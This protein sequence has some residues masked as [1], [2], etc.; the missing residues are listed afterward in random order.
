MTTAH[1]LLNL[2]RQHFDPRAEP[3]A[4]SAGREQTAVL[5]AATRHGEVIVKAH[6]DRERHNSERNAYRRWAPALGERAPRLL[7]EIDDPPAVVITALPG[8]PVAGLPLPPD[9]ERDVFAQAG[10]ILAAWHTAGPPHDTPN[11]AAW[12]ADRG[13]Q[14]LQLA[15]PILPA[16]R[17]F[18]IRAHLRDLAT[19]GPIP[20]VPCHL[21]FT[22]HNLMRAPDGAVRIIDF[23]HARYDLAARDLVRIA[24]RIW[25]D[26]PDLEDAFL[27]THGPLSDLDRQVIEHCTHL[28]NLTATVRATG[29]ALPAVTP[30]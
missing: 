10:A 23:E 25:P 8:A 4:H 17:R 1:D 28:D 6:R 27:A 9:A 3:I 29:R 26:R 14:W 24:S 7:T 11:M 22:P 5:R 18:E 16:T 19:L 12:L 21:D 13:T 2:C 15:D 20:T 30:T